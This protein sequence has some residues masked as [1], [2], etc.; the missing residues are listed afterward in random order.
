MSIDS[1]I[2]DKL[3]PLPTVKPKGWFTITELV[4]KTGMS[5]WSINDKLKKGVERKELEAMEIILDGRKM[6]CY[7]ENDRQA[8]KT[9]AK[10][11]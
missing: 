3:K 10:R 6:K 8:T 9:N 11:G 2:K 1:F 5:R 7:K 4:K